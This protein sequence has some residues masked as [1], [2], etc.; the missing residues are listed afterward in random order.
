MAFLIGQL[1]GASASLVVAALW[2]AIIVLG[3]AW[4]LLALSLV[5]NVRGIR[6]ELARLNAALEST[7]GATVHTSQAERLPHRDLGFAHERPVITAG[8]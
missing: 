6:Q 1:L 7:S 8:R 2:L 3:V 5:R 4:P